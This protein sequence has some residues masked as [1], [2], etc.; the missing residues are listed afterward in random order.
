MPRAEP[1]RPSP[2]D[3]KLQTF[4][5]M[6]RSDRDVIAALKQAQLDINRTLQ[7]LEFDS[8]SS[9]TVRRAQLTLAK[10]NIQARMAVL[11]RQIGDVTQARRLEAANRLIDVQKQ[12]DVFTL[13]RAGYGFADEFGEKFAEAMQLTAESGLDRLNARVQGSSY[14]PLSER[15]YRSSVGLNGQVDRL[16]N[17]AL[18]SALSAREFATLVK[19]FINPS[20]PG[21]VRYAALR[22]SRTEINNSA[23]AIAI[24]QVQDKP[25]VESMRWKL[26]GS[27]PR[28]DICNTYAS[29]GLYPK[30]SVPAKPHPQCFCFVVAELPDEAEFEDALLGGKYDAYL[31]KYRNLQPGQVISST[32]GEIV[33]PTPLPRPKAPAPKKTLVKQAQPA[34]EGRRVSVASQSLSADEKIKAGIRSGI[35]EEQKLSGGVQGQVHLITFNDGSQAIRKVAHKEFGLR[36]PERLTENEALASLVGRTIGAPVPFVLQTGPTEVFMEFVDNAQIGMKYLGRKKAKDEMLKA[37]VDSPEGRRLG[38]FD[39]LISNTDRH[40]GNWMVKDG[41]LVGI[42]HA[43]AWPIGSMQNE[44]KLGVRVASGRNGPFGDYFQTANHLNVN[45]LTHED[46]R[47]IRDKIETIRDAITK[48]D[49]GQ[50]RFNFML[51]KLKQLEEFADGSVNRIKP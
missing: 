21:G 13:K 17:S 37:L 8:R 34:N 18:A 16:V 5:T 39:L 45:D 26:S 3:W 48:V 30:G 28:T 11:W 4:E 29:V 42:D 51:Y 1:A 2:D 23:H 31:E 41:K 35:K 33:P 9:A 27:H 14:T 19:D 50:E 25:W 32:R 36:S 49:F 38:V 43:I 44:L 40:V 10:R 12:L 47:W 22:L 6:V 7:R 46:I 24:H 20:T 15:V